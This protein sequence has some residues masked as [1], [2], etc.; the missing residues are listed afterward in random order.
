MLAGAAA[1]QA[2]TAA[3]LEAVKARLPQPEV[4]T[5]PAPSRLQEPA[6]DSNAADDGADEAEAGP[7]VTAA[8]PALNLQQ[9]AT[10]QEVFLTPEQRRTLAEA[11]SAQE[12][13]ESAVNDAQTSAAAAGNTHAK[14]VS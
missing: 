12:A 3:R 7:G 10:A 9:L 11:Q 13:A 6:G 14:F 5:E 8:V 4:P 1:K 2:A